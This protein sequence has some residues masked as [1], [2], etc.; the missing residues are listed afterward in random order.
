MIINIEQAKKKWKPI[1]DS[2]NDKNIDLETLAILCEET[3]FNINAPYGN[4]PYRSVPFYID[5]KTG[6]EIKDKYEVIKQELKHG[7]LPIMIKIYS[8]YNITNHKEI[9]SYYVRYI[10]NLPNDSLETITSLE[11]VEKKFIR[12]CIKYI[13]KDKIQKIN[14]L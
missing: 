12:D 10:N 8:K 5:W 9:F 4:A 11:L 3:A 6:E 2:L 1:Y 7:F 13:R 14:S